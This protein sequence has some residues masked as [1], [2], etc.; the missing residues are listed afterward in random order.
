M[1]ELQFKLSKFVHQG[2]HCVVLPGDLVP[3]PCSRTFQSKRVGPHRGIFDLWE[4]L[5]FCTDPIV[6]HVFTHPAWS[7]TLSHQVFHPEPCRAP[8]VLKR[9]MS[10]IH[11]TKQIEQLDAWPCSGPKIDIEL[12]DV[13]LRSSHPLPSVPKMELWQC[14][15]SK[16]WTKMLLC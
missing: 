11:S 1:F 2:T 12:P 15:G 14:Y 9:Q 13:F 8:L 3:V 16:V 5:I 6:S 7:T 4:L 10:R